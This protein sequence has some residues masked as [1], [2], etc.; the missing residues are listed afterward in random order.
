[1]SSC[2]T[3][4]ALDVELG[5]LRLAVRAEVLVAVAARDLVVLLEAAD[6]QEL[7][8]ELRR[9]RQRVP[10][11]RR[12]AGGND[13]V[14][15]A[16]RRRTRQRGRFD[17]DVTV[18]V[19]QLAGHPVG[20]GA[21]AQVAGGA[22]AAQVQVAVL[23]TGFL[24]HFNVL[25]DL[26]RQRVGGVE[27]GDLLGHDLDLA[28]GQRRVLV[29]LGALGDGADHLQHELVAEAVEDLFFADDHLGD[30]RSVAQVHECDTTVVTT[31]ADPAGEGY[32]LSNVLGAKG[33]EVVCAQ[34][35][36]PFRRKTGWC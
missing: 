11:T 21:Q 32:G 14:A 10:G 1:M 3:K 36:S 28:G 31:P 33:S 26:E 23:E 25:V 20:L 12:Q 9:L 15:G 16:F 35:S 5:E 22:G 24:A 13:E 19:Q 29:A 4:L 30:A 17:L 18:L 34:H 7:L 27:D 2:S 8:E 6:L